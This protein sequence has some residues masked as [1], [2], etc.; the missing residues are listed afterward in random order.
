MA[1]AKQPLAPWV[2]GLLAAVI[3][4][5]AGFTLSDLFATAPAPESLE[6]STVTLSRSLERVNPGQRSGGRGPY[7]VVTWKGGNARIEHLCFLSG[8]RLPAPLASLRAGDRLDLWSRSGVV[9]QA[10][11]G[12]RV[13]VAYEEMRA[14][15]EEAMKRR[16]LVMVPVLIVTAVVAFYVLL[17]RRR[18]AGEGTE[19]HAAKVRVRIRW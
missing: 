2:V 1:A 7:A 18:Q 6:K 3:A 5:F 15:F 8:C 11:D 4:L 16:S 12:A 9:W 13:I 14:A 17:R 19:S 10:G